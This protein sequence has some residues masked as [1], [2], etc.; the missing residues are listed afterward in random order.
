MEVNFSKLVLEAVVLCAPP[1]RFVLAGFLI[2]RSWSPES[3]DYSNL[4][5]LAIMTGLD[6]P[7]SLPRGNS[8]KI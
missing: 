1:L 8:Q 6:F 2:V 7:N 4:K 5:T 3:L